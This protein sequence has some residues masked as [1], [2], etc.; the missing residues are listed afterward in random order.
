MVTTMRLRSEK[1]SA[2]MTRL[3][4]G[5]VWLRA[6]LSGGGDRQNLARWSQYFLAPVSFPVICMSAICRAVRS[7]FAFA[8]ASGGRYAWF[9]ERFKR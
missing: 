7:V 4:Q 2:G 9:R 8:A 6:M 3:L 1:K 5:P